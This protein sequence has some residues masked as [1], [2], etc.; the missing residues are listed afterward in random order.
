MTPLNRPKIHPAVARWAIRIL[1][2]A[3]CVLKMSIESFDPAPGTPSEQNGLYRERV[4]EIL[5]PW[6][7][8]RRAHAP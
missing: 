8:K 7:C 1:F 5:Q 3:G 6:I 2:Y 4:N